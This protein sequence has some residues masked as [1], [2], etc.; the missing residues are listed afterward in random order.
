MILDLDLEVLSLLGELLG[1]SL[2]FEE[3][4]LPALQFFDEEVVSLRDLRKL[5]IH[6]LLEVD[7]VLP[8]LHCITR[9]LV[10]FADNLV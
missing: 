9:I 6:S 7:K 3:L 4:L 10:P 2:E 8:G 1:E 5:G